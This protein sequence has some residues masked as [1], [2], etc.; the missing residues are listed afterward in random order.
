[1]KALL[2]LA[3]E[4]HFILPEKG[5]ESPVRGPRCLDSVIP[6]PSELP[7]DVRKIKDLEILVVSRGEDQ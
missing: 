5:S 2:T 3:H 6:K 7:L 1:M 4:G